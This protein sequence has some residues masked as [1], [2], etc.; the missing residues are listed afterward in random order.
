MRG[1]RGRGKGRPAPFVPNKE[2]GEAGRQFRGAAGSAQRRGLSASQR[3]RVSPPRA[4]SAHEPQP[5]HE[6][7]R[8]SSGQPGP[9][10]RRDIRAS[11]RL[12]HHR[13]SSHAAPG[14]RL[15]FAGHVPHASRSG[16]GRA[17]YHCR[18]GQRHQDQAAAAPDC[19]ARPV[20]RDGQSPRSHRC[21]HPTAHM[22]RPQ[23][24]R[25]TATKAQTASTSSATIRITP[26]PPETTRARAR[27]RP[28]RHKPPRRAP[29]R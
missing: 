1:N 10:S 20:S 24:H 29:A 6:R 25:S 15:R 26:A 2:H 11:C 23:A 14:P 21:S 5:A 8:V 27:P 18:H 9:D 28:G 17:S 22:M 13:V 7:P 3:S 16:S 12:H 4:A 19:R